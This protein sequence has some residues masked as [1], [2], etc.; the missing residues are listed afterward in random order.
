MWSLALAP[1]SVFSIEYP[2]NKTAGRP[3]PT[4]NVENPNGGAN[5]I[6]PENA[7]SAR[8]PFFLPDAP[9]AKVNHLR[10]RTEH[11]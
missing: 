4:D 6:E 2:I 3:H 11:D 1:C 10:Q 7:R 5:A 9:H 8:P